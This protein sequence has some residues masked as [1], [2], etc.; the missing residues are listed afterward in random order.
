MFL[1]PQ[2]KG[3]LEAAI[4]ALKFQ[5]LAIWQPGLLLCERKE[6]RILERLAMKALPV[7][8]WLS[9]GNLAVET[10]KVAEAMTKDAIKPRFP[11]V[12]HI[13]SNKDM[14]ELADSE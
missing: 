3:Q 1:Y 11:G 9:P 8:N 12:W 6:S 2:V 7:F 13:F 4:Q 5:T 10:E 14:I